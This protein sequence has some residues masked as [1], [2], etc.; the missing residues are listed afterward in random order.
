MQTGEIT[1]ILAVWRAGD[2]AAADRLLPLIRTELLRLAGISG[3]SARIT[4]CSPPRWCKKRFCGCCRVARS[5]PFLRRRFPGNAAHSCG[6]CAKKTSREARESSNP[7]RDPAS[8]KVPS[9]DTFGSALW[10]SQSLAFGGTWT[11][12]PHLVSDAHFGY[13][14][15]NYSQLPPNFGSGCP[16][17]LIGLKGLSSD[18]SI[19]GGL[20]PMSLPGGNLRRLSRTT[21]VP[22]LQTPRTYTIRETMNWIK[23]GHAVKFGGEYLRMSAAVLDVG[24]MLG[25]FS[26]SGRFAGENNQY[27][28]GIADMFFGMPT[29]CSQDS[30]TTFNI[31]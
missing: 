13:S 21:S 12:N 29:T 26:Y 3:V 27:Q 7:H 10:R 28:G 18:E 8:P 23:G 31:N 6:L 30:K 19:C 16:D 9:N 14:R 17:Q 4:P 20:P 24:S 22:Q 11:L 2:R 25:N 1:E 15:G 5:R